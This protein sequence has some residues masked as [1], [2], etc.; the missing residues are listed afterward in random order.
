MCLGGWHEG[1]VLEKA[2]PEYR[3]LNK[4][5]C[6]VR[7]TAAKTLMIIRY[8][9]KIEMAPS[10]LGPFVDASCHNES[11]RC[12][13]CPETV[14]QQRAGEELQGDLQSMSSGRS[15]GDPH[16]VNSLKRPSESAQDSL[17]PPP[18]RHKK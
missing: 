11:Q 4:F 5:D 17:E 12:D 14:S 10:F 15:D 8:L 6:Q 2:E 9:V 16:T 3:T 7:L 18:K 13:A 1:R